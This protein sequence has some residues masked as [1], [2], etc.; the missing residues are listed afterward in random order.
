MLCKSIGCSCATIC[1]SGVR[2]YQYCNAWGQVT[3]N[4][5][6]GPMG[7]ELGTSLLWIERTLQSDEWSLIFWL[8]ENE[9]R[10]E[11]ELAKKR[12]RTSLKAIAQFKRA[13]ILR[14][15]LSERC[16]HG[17]TTPPILHLGCLQ[18]FASQNCVCFFVSCTYKS[19]NNFAKLNNF[20]LKFWLSR[21]SKK[22]KVKKVPVPVV[23]HHGKLPSH[24]H[25]VVGIILP[26]KVK[27]L[28]FN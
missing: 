22:S 16:K 25:A 27:K 15:S 8:K 19:V 1:I 6:T 2:E 5:W 18:N 11:S 9:C 10:A 23:C 26:Q 3:G 24:I 20:R 28:L 7:P 13:C 12:V 21:S 17:T 4:R 14:S